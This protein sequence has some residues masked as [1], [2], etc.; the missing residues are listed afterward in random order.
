MNRLGRILV[1]LH[2]AVGL[3]GLAVQAK[4]ADP[5]K[6]DVNRGQAIA[7]QVCAACHGADGNSAGGAYP[8]LAGQ[9]PEYLVKQLK[10][11]KTQPGAK[12]P[13]RSNPIM[14]GISGALTDQDM[15]NVAAYFATQVPKPGYAHNKATVPLGQKIYRG[16]IADKG[17]PACASCH[18][19][20]GQGIPS[21]YPRL[22][23]QWAEYT[24]AQ[25]TAFQQGPGA[26]NN[27]DVMHAI[28][29]RLSDSEIKAVADYIAGLH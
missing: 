4:A 15:V 29:Q 6:P 19:P 20:A 10:D 21:Q 26:R 7:A 9:H 2:T 28:A 1:V 25:L 11:F 22:S 24:A 17:V 14:A 18:G 12:Q 27:S 8:K 13:A 16:G 23:G 5:A 3:S